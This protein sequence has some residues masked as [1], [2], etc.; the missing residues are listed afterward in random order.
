VDNTTGLLQQLQLEAGRQVTWGL[1]GGPVLNTAAGAITAVVRS[2]KDPTSA[3]GG[4]AIPI[5]KAAEAFEEVKQAMTEPPLAIRRWRD[6]LGKE[7]WQ[8][9]GRSW[10]MRARVDLIV[11]GARHKWSITTDPTGAPAVEIS[12]RDLG[13]DVTEAMF[14]W[15]Q[16]RRISA[17][18]EVELLGRLLARALFPLE[19]AAHLKV[20][21]NADKVLVRLHVAP[22]TKL[23][24]IPWELAAVPGQNDKYL[25]ADSGFQFVRVDDTASVAVPPM[26]VAQTR[27][28]AVVGLPPRWIFPKIYGEQTYQ[29]PRVKDIWDKLKENF[30]GTRF[31]MEPLEN[32]EPFDVR[33]ALRSKTFD[34]LHYI[35]VGRI[36]KYG[37]A[38]LS[39]VD[40]SEGDGTW[41]DANEVLSWAA[42]SRVRL[43]VLEFTLPPADQVVE[44]VTASAL[45]DMLEGSI[46]A[47]VYTRFPVH[48]RQFQSF[49]RLLYLHLRDGGS[50][51]TAVQRGRG[52]LASNR[53]VED[54][55]GFGWFSL[56]TGPRSDIR[57]VQ[58]RTLTPLEPTPKRLAVHQSGDRDEE[59]SQHP[60]VSDDFSR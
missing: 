19:V 50:V 53:S 26:E 45:G 24:D 39:L 25:A 1:S 32:P 44:P 22:E 13:D 41:Q 34:V 2:S 11:K 31:A 8:Q 17:N 58:Q 33:D 43:V 55:A 16:R 35:G 37:Q 7:L 23:A 12:G 59:T 51:E 15:A 10:E 57:L 27:V 40:R 4:G 49:N 36:G 56:V 21:A 28:L 5:S 18:E 3:L 38:Q 30:A 9:L 48:P 54:A 52:M 46:S 60:A 47:V 14:R 20:L 29:W 42:A 6:T